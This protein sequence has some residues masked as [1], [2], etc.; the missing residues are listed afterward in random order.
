MEAKIKAE[1]PKE[2][3]ENYFKNKL[4]FNFDFANIGGDEENN[5]V[6]FYSVLV[7]AENMEANENEIELWKQEKKKL[8]CDNIRLTI[9][10][11]TEVNIF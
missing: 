9:Y 8:Y 10:E 11:L 3:I 7:D 5:N 4:G 6:L 2:A 1:T